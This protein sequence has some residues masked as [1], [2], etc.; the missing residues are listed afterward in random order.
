MYFKSTINL[1]YSHVIFYVQMSKCMTYANTSH[2]CF[3][4]KQNLGIRILKMESQV[5]L[6]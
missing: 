1:K 6:I 4:Q 2:F 5:G 3:E